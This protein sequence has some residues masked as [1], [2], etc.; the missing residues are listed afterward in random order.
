ME[1]KEKIVE[2]YW[3]SFDECNFDL[4][5]N[6]LSHKHKDLTEYFWALSKSNNVLSECDVSNIAYLHF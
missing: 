6:E 2:Q 3:K 5:G 1:T 4:L